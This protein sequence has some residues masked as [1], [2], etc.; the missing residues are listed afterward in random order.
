MNARHIVFTVFAICGIIRIAHAAETSPE[1]LAAQIAPLVT[2]YTIVVVHIDLDRVDFASLD[3]AREAILGPKAQINELAKARPIAEALVKALRQQN[4]RDAYVV[5]NIDNLPVPRVFLALAAPNNAEDVRRTLT[6]TGMD[7]KQCVVMSGLVVTSEISAI[8]QLKQIKPAERPELVE[9]LRAAK[10]SDAQVLFIPSA[11]IRRAFGG[12]VRLPDELG[13]DSGKVLMNGIQWAALEV[14]LKPKPQITLTAKS[15]D[16]SA[17]LALQKLFGSAMG[18]VSKI[19]NT[20]LDPSVAEQ[21][22]SKPQVKADRVVLTLSAENGRGDLADL[23]S[24]PVMKAR[25]AAYRAQ[26]AN[27][28]KQ[29][30][31]SMHNYHDV[32]KHLPDPA[33]RN[34][35]GKPL[36]SWRVSVLPYVGGE[37]LY[38]EFHLNEPWDSEHNKKLIERMPAVFQSPGADLPAGQTTYKIP[39]GAHALFSKAEGPQLREVL[40]GTSNTIMILDVIP[41]NAVPWTKPDDFVLNAEKPTEGLLHSGSDGFFVALAD[42]SVQF[43]APMPDGTLQFGSFNM[44]MEKLPLL[45]DPNDGMTLK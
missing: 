28:L 2:Q 11:D 26:N 21:L 35:Q 16:E 7:E 37:Q 13:S 30:A 15:K 6:Q 3:K 39:T 25:T 34:A 18:L 4:V 40:D 9:A 29:L 44:S 10:D 22:A 32:N 8:E 19:K 5:V 17:A 31:L 36:L 14:L 38:K 20:G 41:E 23:L 45:F 1:Q 33:I 27:N 43:L 24:G 12:T 42:G